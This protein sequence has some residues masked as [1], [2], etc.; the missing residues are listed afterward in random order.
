MR[1]ARYI[2]PI[3]A[4][5][6]IAACT[7]AV[8]EHEASPGPELHSPMIAGPA[9][10][11]R[12]VHELGQWLIGAQAAHD[13]DVATL[14]VAVA[15][16]QAA[17]AKSSGST[18]VSFTILPREQAVAST[19]ECGGATNGADRYIPRESGGDSTVIYGGAHAATPYEAGADVAWGCYQTKGF[20][21]MPGGRCADITDYSPTGQAACASRLPLSAWGG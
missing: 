17:E 10:T 6:A 18:G 13:A 14:M 3:F 1:V 11:A 20:H 7:P 19:G 4:A 8:A 9:E 16:Q 15:E 2:L 12:G 5:F 21:W